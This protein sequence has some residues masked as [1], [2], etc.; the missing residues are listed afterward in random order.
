M[1]ELADGAAAPAAVSGAGDPW[2]ERKFAGPAGAAADCRYPD[3]TEARETPAKGRPGPPPEFCATHNTKRDKQYAYRQEKKAEAEA[4]ARRAA[5]EAGESVP[6]PDPLPTVLARRAREQTVLAE[7]LPR[8]AVALDTILAS[9][10]AAADTEAV[11]AH[12]AAV[13]QAAT[14]RV[15]EAETARVAAAKAAATAQGAA[16]ASARTAAEAV[17]ERDAAAREAST[18]LRE[19]AEADQRANAADEALRQL[20][21]DHLTL[22][23]AHQELM[24]EHQ[25]LTE[26]HTELGAAHSALNQRH[27]ELTEQAG[28][29]EGELTALR[30]RLAE[31]ARHIA[32]LEGELRAT[33]ADLAAARE[34]ADGLQGKFDELRQ[35][36]EADEARHTGELTGIRAERDE[37]VDK[38]GTL[39]T[40]LGVAR[41]RAS[42]LQ[43]QL[44]DLDRDRN[45]ERARHTQALAELRAEH[46][47]TLAELRQQLTRLTAE[48]AALTA[49]PVSPPAVTEAEGTDQPAQQDVPAGQ[50]DMFTLDPAG[51]PLT[52]PADPPRAARVEPDQA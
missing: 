42:G 27:T 40:D 50:M 49:P 18:A 23:T 44:D 10:Q 6:A 45:A 43:R 48:N 12:I 20:A 22:R 36:R 13:D 15:E 19:A 30:P 34:R 37:V 11:A 9:E 1:P 25:R 47:R 28:R 46:E 16:E 29:L 17:A 35:A 41:E 2:L 14:V 24:G 8:V 52:G 32:A 7:L 3:C 4:A 31:Q 26:R 33:H 51:Q 38:L 39:T 21:D 5:E